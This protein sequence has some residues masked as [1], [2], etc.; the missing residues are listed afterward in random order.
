V[1]AIFTFYL[2]I[3]MWFCYVFSSLNSCCIGSQSKHG[4]RVSLI[5]F[6]PSLFGWE[7]GVQLHTSLTSALDEGE[8]HFSSVR[9]H[10]APTD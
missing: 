2:Q 3:F 7:M 5:L 6:V 1:T 8:V 9:Q 4:Y 10:A